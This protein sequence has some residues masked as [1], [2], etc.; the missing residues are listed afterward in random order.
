MFY[1]AGLGPIHN[2]ITVLVGL[3]GEEYGND[4]GPNCACLRYWNILFENNAKR[5]LQFQHFIYTKRLF[6]F[7]NFFKERKSSVK[8]N[9]CLQYAFPNKF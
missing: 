2:I 4:N 8:F 3:G 5:Q 1:K 9:A 7:F 6:F